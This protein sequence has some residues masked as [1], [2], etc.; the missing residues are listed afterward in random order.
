MFN[1]AY[2]D[3]LNSSFDLRSLMISK[4]SLK[5]SL[6]LVFMTYVVVKFHVWFDNKVRQTKCYTSFEDKIDLKCSK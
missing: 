5:R 2:F 1:S 6:C 4:I 3:Q